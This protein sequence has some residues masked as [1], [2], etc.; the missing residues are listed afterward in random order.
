MF[1]EKKLY[2]IELRESREKY[3]LL[4]DNMTDLVA[5]YSPEGILEYISPSISRILGYDAESL[6]GGDP[7]PYIYPED[8][9]VM[10]KMLQKELDDGTDF[11]SAEY[12]LLH[13]DGRWVHFSTN[14]K[15]IRNADGEVTHILANCR[16]ITDKIRSEE[17]IKK[18]EAHYRMLAD[19]ILD[20][21]A[22]HNTNGEFEYV[23]PSALT[24]LGYRP[25]ELMGINPF[26]LINREDAANLLPKNRNK[27]K[28]GLDTFI[29]EFRILHKNGHWVYFETTTKI[30]RDSNNNPVKFL[31]TSRDITEWKLAQFALMES[32]EKYRSLIETSDALIAVLDKE[33]KFLFV[34]DIRAQFFGIDKNSVKGKTMFDFFDKEVAER[35][36][37]QFNTAITQNIKVT[38]ESKVISKGNEYWLRAT[39][40]PMKDV[41][42]QVYAGMVNS[43]DITANKES[44]KKLR[45]QNKE[46][47]EIAF[48]QSHILRSPLSNIKHLISLVDKDSLSEENKMLVNLLQVSAENLDDVVK[49]IV[50]KTYLA[51]TD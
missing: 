6:I 48:L 4:A 11:F 24:V 50:E 5:L 1:T 2:E 19:N 49:Q 16:D 10:N 21:V 8:L 34:N 43:I 32:E 12:R 27:A 20:L 7:S 15:L 31:S 46:L 37:E 17:A 45:N 25:E 14:R 35:F 36:L 47:R 9:S 13:A 28:D 30:I 44:E 51:D 42:G 26:E 23:S 40:Q 3:K 38:Y 41:K 18:S 33:G 22:L 29:D 39:I